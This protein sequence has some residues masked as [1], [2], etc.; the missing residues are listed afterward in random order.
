M[1]DKIKHLDYIQQTI[2][3][4]AM[5]SFQIKAWNIGL[6]T[7]VLA[8]A[9]GDKNSTFLW[10]AFLP[11]LM[12]WYLDSFFLRQERL[13]RA[14]YDDVRNKAPESI[15]FSMDTKPYEKIKDADGHDVDNP[16]MKRSNVMFSHT[17]KYFHGIVLV[18]IILAM[19]ILYFLPCPKP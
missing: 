13:Y 17:L 12:L 5:V 14:L 11:A 19:C 16:F 18:V 4:M 8:F 7:A 3:R 10:A 2:T 1:T 6:V 15:D 9:A